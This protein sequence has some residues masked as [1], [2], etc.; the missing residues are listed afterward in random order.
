M[1][2]RALIGILAA[3]AAVGVAVLPSAL[4][5]PAAAQAQAVTVTGIQPNGSSVRIFYKPVAGAK[6]YRV[7]D[8]SNPKD[9]KY[10]GM[11]H[12]QPGPDCPG[13]FCLHTFATDSSGNVI[14]NGISPS[15][16]TLFSVQSAN[17]V[18]SGANTVQDVP[19]L[20]IE[21]NALNDTNQHTLVVQA[22]D[23]LG[24]A[25]QANLYSTVPDAAHTAL[26]SGGMLG[27]NKGTTADGNVSTNGQGPYTNK[28]NVI[29]SSQPF[30]VQAQPSMSPLSNGSQTFL[31]TFDQ[32]EASTVTRTA[33]NACGTDAAGNIGS[34]TYTV[35]A[36]T[37]KAWNL[38][39]RQIDT[40]N[41]MPF[42]SNSHF[43]DMVFDGAT[44]SCHSAPSDTI[45]GSLAMTPQQSITTNGGIVHLTME[46]DAHMSFRRWL[47]FD[48]SP[49]SDPIQS[50]QQPDGH[51][52]N[53]NDQALYFEVSAH[54]CSLD[55]Y[56]GPSGSTSPSAAYSSTCDV[57][58]LFF[59]QYS[60][61][62]GRGLDDRSRLDLFVSQSH[63]AF[64]QDG[65]LI[66]QTDY[67]SSA[68]S[69]FNNPVKAYYTHYM[70]HSD[71]DIS[72]L[73]TYSNAGAGYC[74]PLNSYWFNDPVNGT[75]AGGTDCG[76]AYPAGYGFPHSDERHWDNMG[77][78]VLPASATGASDFSSLGSSVALPPIQAP[79]FT[80]GSGSSGS[81]S[82]S[83]PT[84]Q[85]ATA[86]STTAP[87]TSTSA[88]T[89]TRVPTSTSTTIPTTG[90]TSPPSSPGEPQNIDPAGVSLN[91]NQPAHN[92]GFNSVATDPNAPGSA[93]LGTTF[94]G[95]YKTTNGGSSWAKI[96]T[97]VG[98]TLVDS[99][100]IWNLA[101]DPFNRGTVYAASG[102]GG[103][104]GLKSTDGG[105]TWKAIFPSTNSVSQQLG[106]S[107]IFNVAP[108]PFS[109]NHLI[110]AFHYYWHGTQDSGVIES[111]DGGNTWQAH[112]PP[113]GAGWGPTNAVFFLDNS[114]TWL[115]ASE[116][117]GLWR[118]TNSGQTWTQ[119]NSTN[120]APGGTAAL[121]R[122]PVTSALYVAIWNGILKST[123]DGVTWQTIMTGLPYAEYE[124]VFGDGV[125]LY[126]APSNPGLGD[127]GQ[128]HGPWYTAR[129]D[130]S[131]AWSGVGTTT[132]CDNAVCNG[133]VQ[134]AYDATNR[135]MYSANW[136]AGVWVVPSSGNGP[137]STS[138]PVPTS[139]NAP[140][141]T[142]APSRTPTRTSTPVPTNTSAPT[143]TST[144][145]PTITSTFTTGATVSPAAIVAGN[146]EQ[147]TAT[148][149][150]SGLATV[151]IEVEVH[152]P[153]GA[154]VFQQAWDN[155]AFTPGQKR[156]FTTSAT[157]QSGGPL[158][159]YVVKI[160][161]FTPNWGTL[162]SWND[163][164]ARFGVTP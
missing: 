34:E 73:T 69:W 42:I 120:I 38:E 121:Y 45:Y 142:V 162:L 14:V 159:T 127:N 68:L 33:L 81:S 19:A 161:V 136:D 60:M 52:L 106:T 71:A 51:L 76:I 102:A 3:A 11:A 90:P 2:Q 24:P 50:W 61:S 46:V 20:D 139:T 55:I 108:D 122:N 164:A 128:A 28:P 84:T 54:G 101:V 112:N 25:P 132:T 18:Q 95:I 26:A 58:K 47:A 152:D 158:G 78:E 163:S 83:T 147:I 16:N 98:N 48:L 12:Y 100:Q 145:A 17:S 35:N 91:P 23:A 137:V 77:F 32:S 116:K 140:T 4:L 44:P 80:S 93:Y 88:P 133:P 65:Q 57:S 56:N 115:L 144:V 6:D 134:M 125:N 138:T 118:T 114:T 49:A 5:Q 10:A 92:Y 110:A 113:S 9:V 59:P 86:T 153:S 85:P 131:T 75:P 87:A 15:S 8:T 156:T 117:N 63:L 129:E 89:S 105:V 64:F 96:D 103:G 21:W 119:V 22:V 13:I 66:Y 62:L 82:T 31:D 7:Y 124:T 135:L 30:V 27:S 43:M 1:L 72:D 67:P 149:Q 36:G 37:S 123:D 70:Y 155:Q 53:N 126:T 160:G 39:L 97:G 74:Y 107:D 151:L 94:Q 40:D 99:G 154:V 130:G 29:A 111:S 41:S 150:S 148:V 146:S 143:A 79:Q 109:A 141:S 157:T 104:G